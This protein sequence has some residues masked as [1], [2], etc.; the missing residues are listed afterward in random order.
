MKLAPTPEQS[1]FEE[2]LRRA[3]A[4]LPAGDAAAQWRCLADLGVTGLGIAEDLGGSGGGRD[5]IA[6]AACLLGEAGLRT[7]YAGTVAFA[8]SVL[9]QG[10][11]SDRAELLRGIAAGALRVAPVVAEW[12]P[13]FTM[14]R[15]EAGY[16]LSGKLTLVPGGGWADAFL[17]DAIDVAGTRV[18][19]WM[20]ADTPG[21]S[22]QP[23]SVVDGSLAADL[24][25]AG[26]VLPPAACLAEG[27]E[28]VAALD[29]AAALHQM[30]RTWEA[31]A[32]I[33][34]LVRMTCDHVR[35]R[36]QFGQPLSGFQVIQH[37]VARMS[38]LATEARAAAAYAQAECAAPPRRRDRALSSAFV[39]VA[40]I[41]D[42]VAR[43][44]VQLH[45]AIGFT[46]E[47]GLSRP[48]K[49]VFAFAHEGHG[50]AWHK[51]RLAAIMR[52]AD[53]AGRALACAPESGQ[54]DADGMSLALTP[55]DEA[56][57]HDV[58]AFVAGAVD[59]NLRRGAR[60]A[61]GVFPEPDVAG[62]WHRKLYEQGWIAPYLPR[63]AGGTGW[64]P[65]QAYLF[66][67]TCARGG[68]PSLQLQGLRMLAPVLLH[69]GTPEQIARYLP[70]ILSGDDL[71][72]QGY[73][74]PG[75]GSD[76][77]ALRTRAVADGADYVINGSKIWTTQAQHA[78]HMFALV[79]TSQ[80]GRRQEGISFLLI[81]MAT[82][83]IEIRPIRTLAGELE[84]NEV[85]F[86]NVRV[87]QVNLLGAEN[88]GWECAKYLLDFERG[89]STV[90]GPLRAYFARA[91]GT[92][93]DGDD[94]L[95][96]RLASVAAALDA[97][98]MGELLAMAQTDSAAS[99][100]VAAS[101]LKLRMAEVRQQIG[102]LA[103]DGLGRD[104]LR[105]P[106]ARPLH[107]QPVQALAEEQR[108]AIVPN[109]FNDL[110]Y[111][112]FAGS[113]EIQLSIIASALS[114]R[115]GRK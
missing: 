86:D 43:E 82:P 95:D 39:R 59:N 103:A 23:V 25:C 63:E 90:S 81:D 50:L 102:A 110:A 56:F 101:A 91:V 67:H 88:G 15:T 100:H 19:L 27:A 6:L 109:H 13:D 93:E 37:R 66:E 33:G 4:A 75:A 17:I 45:G 87:P 49:A 72:C 11:R 35:T 38:V 44:A 58:A 53:E 114:L 14:E 36:E 51:R 98:E 112:I 107:H 73:S 52:D 60:L 74:E 76:L 40:E 85:F 1:A 20:P 29:G 2:G 84:F 97:L 3:L 104:A 7:P 70:G 65:V 32:A 94:T 42:H 89:G 12:Q 83:G 108:V 106:A 18:A 105:W 28:A 111:S 96:D 22:V 61:I 31:A 24:V 64:T 5:E 47:C 115:G 54:D 62:P 48:F 16:R 79:R 41:G 69:Y 68:A 30:V 9:A 78:S 92:L 57:R 99:G 26:V 10:P 34:E 8:A 46:E 113:S 80:E 55:E 77:A 71:W 21:L